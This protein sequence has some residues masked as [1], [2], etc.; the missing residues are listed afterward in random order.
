MRRLSIVMAVAALDA[1]MHRLIVARAYSH[2]KLPSKLARLDMSFEQLLAQADSAGAAARDKPTQPRFRVGVKRDL[3]DRLLRETYQS[4]DGVSTA[5]SMAGISGGWGAIGTKMTA[6]LQPDAIKV[7]LNGIV[8]RRNQIVHEG[9]YERSERP[10]KP[11]LELVSAQSVRADIDFIAELV[12]AIHA[13][14]S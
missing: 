5:L 1:Y 4:Y 7:R 8:R 9:D 12:D 6:P 3:R 14:A 2:R 10:R 13:V 11:K